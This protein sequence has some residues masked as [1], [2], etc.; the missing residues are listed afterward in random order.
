MICGGKGN[1]DRVRAQPGIRAMKGSHDRRLAGDIDEDERGQ[2]GGGRLL[3]IGSDPAEIM[4]MAQRGSSQTVFKRLGA[5]PFDQTCR[6]RRAPATIGIGAQDDRGLGQVP[7]AAVEIDGALVELVEPGR[8]EADP[9]AVMPRQ[10]GGNQMPG[11]GLRIIG[12][13]SGCAQQGGTEIGRVRGGQADVAG[14]HTVSLQRSGIRDGYHRPGR[15]GTIAGHTC[16]VQVWLRVNF[17]FD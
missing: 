14:L 15:A 10:T 4:D 9:V 6:G 8:Q 11:D 2:P 13:C 1:A 17:V 7:I 12:P 16:T 5:G 3:A